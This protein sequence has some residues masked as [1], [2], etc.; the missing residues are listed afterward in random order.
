[1]F[2]GLFFLFSSA[3]PLTSF[4]R[5]Y[6]DIVFAEAY[7]IIGSTYVTDWIGPFM[8]LGF[9]LGTAPFVLFGINIKEYDNR[10]FAWAGVLLLIYVLAFVLTQ[11]VDRLA[12]DLVV[13]SLIY[14]SVGFQFGATMQSRYKNYLINEH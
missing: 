4:I 6:E 2:L 10:I 9:F 7:P 3:F 13:I 8:T 1:M 11:Y 14:Y 5:K 12:R